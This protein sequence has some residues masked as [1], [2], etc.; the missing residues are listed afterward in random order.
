MADPVRGQKA[1]YVV[2]SRVDNG[3]LLNTGSDNGSAPSQDPRHSRSARRLSSLGVIGEGLLDL[4]IAICCAYFIVFA[5]LVYSR[6]NQPLDRPGNRDLLEAAKYTPTIFPILF[7]AVVAKFLRA[8]AAIK[9][10][11]GTSVLA[12]EY[13]LQSRTVFSTFTAPITLKTINAL[14]PFLFLLWALSPLGG[15]A[16]LRVISTQESFS[17]STQNFTYLAFVSEFSNEGVNSASAEPLIPINALFTAA[18]IGSANTK[19]LPQD[20]FSNVKIPIYESLSPEDGSD[21]R[22]VPDSSDVEWSSLTGLPIQNLP[23]VG[24]SRFTMNTGYMVTS[25]NVSGHN[26]SDGYRQSLEQFPGWSGANYA[27]TPNSFNTFAV[28]NFTFRSLDLYSDTSSEGEVLTVANCTVGMSYVEVQIKC[29]GQTCQSVAVRPS[30]NPASHQPNHSYSSLS[31]TD[32]TPING[33]GQTDLFYLAFF[34]DFTNATN[35]TVG[36]D[37]SFCPPSAIEAYLADPANTLLQTST[38]KL[39]KLGDD[40]I[41]KRFTQLINTYW[42]DSIAPSAVSGNFTVPQG[43]SLLTYN[44]DS[45]LGTITTSQIVVKCDYRWLAIMLVCSLALFVIGLVTVVLTACRRGPDLLDKFSSLLRDNPYANIPH[46][47]S[48][49]NAADQSRRLGDLIVRLGDVRPEEDLGYVAIG[50]LDGN[51]TVQKLST[52][53]MYA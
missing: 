48:M 32:W 36:C 7:S 12:L 14:T 53:R 29:D 16:G 11:N 18:I 42:I 40:I 4:L 1:V 30:K 3:P 24:V 22:S 26:W 33:L 34:P 52:R 46:N 9:L 19:A 49:E 28:T 43:D 21:W 35:P 10:E 31:V 27:L 38:T 6:R 25:C 41:S 44:T 15:Q 13:L 23:S 2:E 47:S 17:N 39:W 20:Q 50:V 5:A 45:N 8:I 51:H 37:T